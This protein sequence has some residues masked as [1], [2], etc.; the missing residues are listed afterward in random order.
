MASFGPPPESNVLSYPG[1][2]GNRFDPVSAGK[3]WGEAIKREKDIGYLHRVLDQHGKLG[4]DERWA[5]DMSRKD[6][7]MPSHGSLEDVY[8]MTGWKL[9]KYGRS[10]QPDIRHL[11]PALA[12]IKGQKKV[13]KKV[14]D[15]LELTWSP[16]SEFSQAGSQRLAYSASAPSM[17][18]ARDPPPP[19]TPAPATGRQQRGA[20]PTPSVRSVTAM[21]RTAPGGFGLPV[22]NANDELGESRSS[23]R[24]GT[25][26]RYKIASLV[27]SE[28]NSQ[29]SAALGTRLRSQ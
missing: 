4:L 2:S 13:R 9:D 12:K 8:Y 20:P 3:I 27:C 22:L 10:Q 18:V 17:A 19:A 15:D 29:C 23:V 25:S 7:L 14:V 5:K 11:I 6:D 21:S 28:V 26:R 1:I 24:K 16:R